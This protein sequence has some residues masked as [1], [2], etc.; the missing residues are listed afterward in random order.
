MHRFPP[1][2][3]RF[4]RLLLL[5]GVLLAAAAPGCGS[6]GQHAL[7]LV[8]PMNQCAPMQSGCE[9][10][11][12][13]S[14]LE[15]TTINISVGVFGSDATVVDCPPDLNTGSSS[16]MVAYEPGQDFYMVDANY[17]R[18]GE[19]LY[20]SGGPFSEDETQTPWTLLLR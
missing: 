5:S 6:S 7:A 11:L 10:F 3:G 4:P 15:L 19:T 18:D 14:D 13:C 8:P 12:G 16:V 1:S 17:P 2:G 9:Q 20:L